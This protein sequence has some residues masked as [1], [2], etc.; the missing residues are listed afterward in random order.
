MDDSLWSFEK[1]LETRWLTK[2]GIKNDLKKKRNE[3]KMV[4]LFE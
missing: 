4:D 2:K 1:L 3:T